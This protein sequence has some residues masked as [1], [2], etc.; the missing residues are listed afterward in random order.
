MNDTDAMSLAAEGVTATAP[1]P[2]RAEWL[3]TAQALL[4]VLTAM[5]VIRV[6][7]IQPFT[8]PS[9]SMENTLNIG[10][11]LLINKLVYDFRS[12]HRGDIIVF[13]GTGSWDL[14]KPPSNSNIFS[15]FF[16]DVEGI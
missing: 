16:D 3:E 4:V 11:R 2:G 12:I 10:D 7:L 1:R 8:I 5:L 14:N 6:G 13:Y 9:A 15:R